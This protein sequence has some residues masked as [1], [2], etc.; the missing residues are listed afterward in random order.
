MFSK[1]FLLLNAFIFLFIFGIVKLALSIENYLVKKNYEYIIKNYENSYQDFVKIERLQNKSFFGFKHFFATI[2]INLQGNRKEIVKKITP[3]L[4]FKFKEG[5]QVEA[6]ITKD[7]FGNYQVFL[8]QQIQDEISLKKE[9]NKNIELI[10]N[11]FLVSSVFFF[12]F[13]LFKKK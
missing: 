12:I 6:R 5:N 4:Y 13:S 10:C 1:E 3:T 2:S 7:R 8:I 11:F 9:R